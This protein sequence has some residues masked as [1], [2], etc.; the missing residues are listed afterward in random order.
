M[1]GNPGGCRADRN[2]P[3][4]GEEEAE[5][6]VRSALASS[7]AEIRPPSRNSNTFPADIPGRLSAIFRRFFGVFSMH[8][9][10]LVFDL[11]FISFR[12]QN[13][14]KMRADLRWLFGDFRRLFRPNFDRFFGRNSVEPSLL[15]SPRFLTLKIARK[16]VENRPKLTLPRP[17]KGGGPVPHFSRSIDLENFESLRTNFSTLQP[18]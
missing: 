10:L 5:S 18:R 3:R 6:S 9:G 17:R 12:P 2:S 7:G 4:A 15:H 8:E 14:S 16:T 13:G 11:L 1:G